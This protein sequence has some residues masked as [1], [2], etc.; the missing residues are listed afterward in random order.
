MFSQDKAEYLVKFVGCLKHTDGE[1]YGKPFFLL[2]WQES[3]VSEF[4]GTLKDNGAR[5]YQYLYLE[6]P[7]KNGKS[8]LAAAL[9]LYHTFA[10]GEK[11][12][13][14]YLCAADKENASIIFN[15]A[16]EMIRLC[17]GL[18]KR[19]KITESKKELY[20]NISGT[21]M[22][23]MSSEA[24]SKHGYKP[25]CVIFDELHAQPSRDLW[26]IMTFGTGSAR[27]QPVW[28]VLTTAGDDPDHASIGWEQHEYARKVIN[29]RKG[30]I[31]DAIADP[32]WLPFIF[33]AAEDADIY[34]E[35]VWYEAN[36]SLGYTIPIDV[37]RQEALAAKNSPAVEKLFKWLRLNQWVSLKATSWLPLPLFDSTVGKWTRRDLRGKRCYVGFDL[38]STVDLTAIVALFPPQDELESWSV[39]FEPFMPADKLKERISND[40]NMPYEQWVTDGYINTTPGDVTDYEFVEAAVLDICDT[41]DVI[42]IGGDQWNSR[43]LTQRLAKSQPYVPIIEIHQT[44]AGMSPA[45]KH[46][47]VLLRR[48]DMEH[49]DNPVARWNF[50]NVK[51][52]VDGNE[53]LKPMKNKSIG[54]IDITVAW[55][56]AVATAIIN[57][58]AIDISAE[59]LSEDWGV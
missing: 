39:I 43:M 52:Y 33:G 8:E 56:N 3:A 49:E 21:K 28:I 55:I 19:A 36:P 46:M 24:F 58:E 1:W 57:G 16:L 15:V 13:E 34:D 12:G 9:G 11:R 17:P 51:V 59:I 2:P 18:L 5:Q 47:E 27:Y 7:K 32:V 25:S 14:V 20:D 45:M 31:E 22:K 37:L 35:S 42:M 53:N 6:I 30:E 10:D 40:D 48:G 38:G 26:D 29:Y 50:G 23:V 41:Y 4:Y 54:R 44:I